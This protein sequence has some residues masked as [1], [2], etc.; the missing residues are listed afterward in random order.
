MQRLHARYFANA[1]AAAFQADL[2]EK[3]WVI[4]LFDGSTLVGFSTQQSTVATLAGRE[5]RFL[6][7][8]DTIVAHTHRNQPGLAG[9]F[10]HLF[11]RLLELHPDRDLHWFLIC[12][13]HR[14]YRFLPVFF[15]EFLPAPGVEPDVS[16]TLKPLLDAVAVAKFGPQYDPADGLVR[17]A[18]RRDRLRAAWAD[19]DADRGRDACVAFFN[20]AN[21][22]WRRGDEL[23]CLAPLSHANMKPT[24]W[25]VIRAVTP[26]W[27]ATI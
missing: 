12:K 5:R 25:R 18:P 23:A 14:T 7:S 17:F 1:R 8:G 9:A 24:A 10:G 6:F 21:P 22:Q 15:R 19:R 2:A 20:R 26:E 4:R 13:G 16:E 11:L 3:D 27:G